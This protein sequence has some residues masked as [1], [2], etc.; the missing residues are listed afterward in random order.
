MANCV[1]TQASIADEFADVKKETQLE[2]DSYST[3]LLPS[4]Y[5]AQLARNSARRWKSKHAAIINQRIEKTRLERKKRLR[6]MESPQHRLV[7]LD[8]LA[9]Q[10]MA[11]NPV[12]I[13]LRI[14]LIEKLLPCLIMGLEKLLT[15]VEKRALVEVETAVP[16]FNP[17]NYLA[18]YL[19]RNN[20]RYSNFPEASAYAKGLRK[21]AED[22]KGEIFEIDSN[23]LVTLKANAQV[24]RMER[25]KMERMRGEELERRGL[26]LE[27]VFVTWAQKEDTIPLTMVSTLGALHRIEEALIKLTSL[28]YSRQDIKVLHDRKWE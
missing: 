18:Q 19:M 27:N 23:R 28:H 7:P 20:P 3:K 25:E 8:V 4:P 15:E 6:D 14:Y 17:V 5:I 26:L 9:R 1:L 13:D 2:E 10:W 21:V 11:D 16:N 12:T 22:L 24:K